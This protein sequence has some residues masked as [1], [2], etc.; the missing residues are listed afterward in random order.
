MLA[1]LRDADG[2]RTL[3]VVDV[4]AG[5]AVRRS[6]RRTMR[7]PG[8]EAPVE[9]VT[10]QFFIPVPKTSDLLAVVAFSTPTLSLEDEMIA[11][12]DSILGTFAFT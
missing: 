10:R 1:E 3:E 4:D 12:F 9:L 2:I 6:G 5:R 7:F 8:S 11:L